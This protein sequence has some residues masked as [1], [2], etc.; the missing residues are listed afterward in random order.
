MKIKIHFINKGNDAIMK[1]IDN[2]TL[3]R[4]QGKGWASIT[5][6]NNQSSKGTSI[7]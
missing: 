1:G 3:K 7:L 4:K 6:K 5:N 2:E